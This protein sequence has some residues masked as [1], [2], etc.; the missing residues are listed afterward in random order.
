[1]ANMVVKVVRVLLAYA[2]DNEYRADNPAT[3][4]K[5]F[6]LGEHRA[7]TDQECATFEAR[8]PAGSMQRRAYLL[9]KFTGRRP[10]ELCPELAL[11]R[12]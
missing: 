2:V 8:W 10:S 12:R 9:A 3:R 1:M 5:L 11:L 4:I 7:W 6:K